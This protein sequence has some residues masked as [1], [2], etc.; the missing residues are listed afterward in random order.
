M[1]VAVYYEL[2]VYDVELIET[3]QTL[4]NLVINGLQ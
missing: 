4:I 1:Y 3:N 2:L